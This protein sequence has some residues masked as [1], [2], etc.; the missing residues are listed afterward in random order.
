MESNVDAGAV[1]QVIGWSAIVLLAVVG[2]VAGLIAAVITGGS[3]AK[4]ILVGI[5]GA[6]ALPFVLALLGVTAAIGAGLLAI[7]AIGVIGAVLLVLLIKAL[8]GKSDRVDH[9]TDRRL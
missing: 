9:R 8:T 3:K 5:V 1:M 4:Y 6:V 2:L 7:L